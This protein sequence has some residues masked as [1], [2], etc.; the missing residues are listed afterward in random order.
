[1]CRVRPLQEESVDEL[2]VFAQQ[3]VDS[4]RRYCKH[5]HAAVEAGREFSG[6]LTSL[7]SEAWTQRF[8]RVAALLAAFGDTFEEVTLCLSLTDTVFC[9]CNVTAR[10]CLHLHRSRSSRTERCC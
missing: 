8:G 1:M 6:L 4:C 2:R 7:R 9:S 5:G 10:C 3:L